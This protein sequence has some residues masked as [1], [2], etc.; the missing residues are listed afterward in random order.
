V[1]VVVLTL[2]AS[3]LFVACNEAADE[4]GEG[5]PTVARPTATSQTPTV[6]PTPT[7]T[8]ARPTATSQSLTVQPTPTPTAVVENVGVDDDPSWGPAD[9]S[10]TII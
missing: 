8:A 7:P 9:A 6:Q 2:F 3:C 10:V 1:S 4:D 5:T